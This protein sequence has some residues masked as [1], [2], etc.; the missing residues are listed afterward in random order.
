[1][2]V[3]ACVCNMGVCGFVC[4]IRYKSKLVSHSSKI[5]ATIMSPIFITVSNHLLEPENTHTLTHRQGT[6]R[7]NKCW[8]HMSNH[9]TLDFAVLCRAIIWS[10]YL[11]LVLDFLFLFTVQLDSCKKTETSWE[12]GWTLAACEKLPNSLLADE[13]SPHQKYDLL[14]LKA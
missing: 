10:F 5:T 12:N 7:V 11:G 8:L 6:E 13:S 3:C 4:Y 1:M 14:L 2:W 9:C